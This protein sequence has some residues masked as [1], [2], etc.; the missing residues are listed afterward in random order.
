M[1]KVILSIPILFLSSIFIY[2]QSDEDGI[3]YE[4]NQ[5]MEESLITI[6]SQE[7]E[8]ENPNT[9]ITSNDYFYL[10]LTKNTQNPFNKKISFTINITPKIDSPKTQI[11]WSTPSVFTVEKE[12]S[13]F[14]SLSK[15]ETYSYSAKLNPNK[16]GTY[17]LSVNVVSWQYNS[18]KSASV[19]YNMTINKSLI[20]QP[21]DST[22]IITLVLFIL[23]VIGGS[24]LLIY[25]SIKSI[26]KL[27]IK[28]KIWLTPPI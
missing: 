2:A 18:N 22:F 17:T 23:G 26:K 11:I 12:H 15:G 9:S 19:D 27:A 14:V 3:T 5:Q 4:Q 25:I 28:A 16:E 10:E 7:L 6:D 1:K 20:L 21:V 24:A 13:D 8:D